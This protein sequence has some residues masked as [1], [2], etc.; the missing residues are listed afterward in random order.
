MTTLPDDCTLSLSDWRTFVRADFHRIG[1]TTASSILRSML[2]RSGPHHY[3]FWMRSCAALSGRPL[4]LPIFVLAR[5]ALRRAQ[6]R[7]AIDIPFRTVI[8]PGL[9]IGHGFG[10]VVNAD[11]VIGSNCNLSQGVTMGQAN[12]G[13]RK[14]AC[15]LGD[16]V[17][18]GP[19]VSVVGN[20]SI[21][22]DVAVGANS[23]VVHDI[24]ERSV[25]VGSPGR[26][27]STAS[28]ASYVENAWEGPQRVPSSPIS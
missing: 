12:R 18:L 3:I 15:R 25:V 26:V 28:S 16:R 9:Y 13:P 6:Y 8:G 10:I 7:Y 24:P 22:N 19:N 14:G 21:G 1:R 11:A 2:F 17:Y 23:V 5:L 27:V 4:L 20:L